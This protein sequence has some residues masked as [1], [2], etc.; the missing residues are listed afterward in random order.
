[1]K[2]YLS[3]SVKELKAQKLMSALILIAVMLSCMMTTALGGSLGILQTLRIRQAASLN[4]D[5][6]ATFHQLTEEQ[7]R[8]LETD[9]RLSSVGSMVTV[10][11]T[12]LGSSGLTLFARE[13]L[14]NAL[15]AYPG[16]GIILEGRLPASPLEIALPENAL[17]YLEGEIQIGDTVSLQMEISRMDGSLPAYEFTADYL[18]TGILKSN[19]ISLTSGT[20]DA[21]LGC[22]SASALLPEDYLLYSTD[23]KT[24]D[25]AD[26]QSVVD[27]LAARLSVEPAMIQYNWILLD[28][29]GI[30]YDEAGSSDT[31]TGFSFMALSCVLV[32]ALVLLA[33]GLVIYN[34]L[35]I[36][37]TKRITEYG[38][39]RAI[40]GERRQ[41][42][43]L[44]A[45]QLFILC[46][47]GIPVGLFAG[48]MSARSILAAATGV[49]NP[50]L[51]L[52]ESSAALNETIRGTDSGGIAPYLVSAAVTTCF[53]ML[54]A[55]PAARYA[56]RV[57]PT[58]AM[59]GQRTIVRRRRQ[60]TAGFPN[61]SSVKEK[62]IRHFE[63]WYAWLN[64]KRGRGRTVITILSL[65]M[66][67]T[68]FVALQSFTALLD[69]G[70]DV[71]NMHLG[72][73]SITNEVNGFSQDDLAK[74]REQ[75]AV[76]DLAETMLSTYTQDEKG[77]LPVELD[78]SLQSWEAFHIAG[79]DDARL[80]SY[81]EG[82]TDEDFTEL[83]SGA[84]CIVKNPIPFSYE[85][86]E[87]ETTRLRVN[88]TVTVNGHPL[89][90]AGITEATVTV[91]NGDYVNGVQI[92]VNE[93]L[94]QKLTGEN[95]YQEVYPTL[96]QGANREAFETWLND[97]CKENPG[98]HWLSYEETDAQLAESFEQIRL[99]SWGLILFI[100]L[101][102]I[103]NII[104]TVYSNIHTRISEIG[105]QRAIGMSAA[106]LYRTFLWEGAY[107]GLLASAAGGLLG[108]LCTIFVNAAASDT[109]AVTAVP[110]LSILEAAVI[111]VAA[112]LLATAVPLGAIAKLDIVPSME[113][114]E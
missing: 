53:A 1:M 20:L 58:L 64:L 22:G 74:L 65:V 70:T 29:L 35:K 12:E 76:E 63:A 113:G 34:I 33:A 102:G 84:A 81:A 69:T 16:N 37:V 56:S 79:V 87:V 82:L 41:I 9:P 72:D 7:M 88:D 90:V 44:V 112:C 89:R 51:F 108:Y 30:A 106:S 97:F 2:S 25:L 50:D 104:N 42:Y 114:A 23:F 95:R 60:R 83:R 54:A 57:S 6:Y 86:Q 77:M 26:F 39:L 55:F 111:S 10:G 46:G 85:G 94:Y 107:Y 110:V 52:A 100:G 45:L 47:I 48:A 4:G 15:D 71:K 43:R 93:E 5:R 13:Y 73:Y 75:E 78:L 91:N 98:S 27:D 105:I 17:P 103:L 3:F 19:Y 80:T 62:P 24:E 36:S 99:L 38:T 67:I 40:G 68:V 59:T 11:H 21:V 109:L 96:K 66:S 31:D 28:A 32:G 14:G 101:I 61:R 92:M 8:Q 18:I 49:L